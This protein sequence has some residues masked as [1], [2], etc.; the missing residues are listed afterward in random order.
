MLISAGPRHMGAPGRLIHWRPFKLI[1]FKIF[2]L[3]RGWRSF[4][5]ARAQIAYYFRKKSFAC[6]NL[7]LLVYPNSCL[8]P[9]T[10]WH[11]GQLPGWP[12][13][14]SGPDVDKC[15]P[16][17]T[18]SHHRRRQAS[19]ISILTRNFKRKKH[20]CRLARGKCW[21]NAR[22]F[23]RSYYVIALNETQ[24]RRPWLGRRSQ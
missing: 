22:S 14:L 16:D 17:Y 7:S 11:P 9:P 1:L 20:S 18:T 8:A 4:L 10:G 3:G 21:W 2:G 15:L 12:A 5:R 23:V 13:P 19:F 6:R 24:C